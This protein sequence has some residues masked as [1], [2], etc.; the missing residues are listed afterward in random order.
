M[1]KLGA[2]VVG[3]LLEPAQIERPGRAAA[4]GPIPLHDLLVQ[5]AHLRHLAGRVPVHQ[6]PV[7]HLT[8]Q[9]QTRRNRV[10]WIVDQ[11]RDVVGGQQ[12]RRADEIGEIARSAPAASRRSSA[13]TSMKG[14]PLSARRRQRSIHAGWPGP[15]CSGRTSASIPRPSNISSS[16]ARVAGGELF[17]RVAGRGG[18]GAE[19]NELVGQAA[20]WASSRRVSPRTAG[21]GAGR[22]C[23]AAPAIWAGRAGGA[24]RRARAGGRG[25]ARTTA[26]CRGRAASRARRGRSRSAGR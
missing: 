25:C 16:G 1:T 24:R 3:K 15:M 22:P 23:R 5:R 21:P 20:R 4:T 7:D 14:K 12:L 11:I 18:V 2:N 6:R 17:G 13:G 19:R 26:A 9:V 10:A 8:G